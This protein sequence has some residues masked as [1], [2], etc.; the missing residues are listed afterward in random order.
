MSGCDDLSLGRWINVP[1]GI[2][3]DVGDFRD[4]KAINADVV[5]PPRRDVLHASRGPTRPSRGN[6]TRRRPTT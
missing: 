5:V 3:W 2:D 1:E 4:M 6:G